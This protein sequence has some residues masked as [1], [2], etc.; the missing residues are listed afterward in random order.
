M[1]KL[2]IAALLIGVTSFAQEK[3]NQKQLT[4]EQRTEKRL[5]HLKKDLQLNSQQEK[6][7]K[8]ALLDQETRVAALKANKKERKEGQK[9]TVQEKLALKSKVNKEQ[10]TMSAK[11]KT[12]LTPEQ[13]KKWE[14]GKEE[15]VEK[16]KKQMKELQ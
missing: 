2:I 8:Q 9:L 5:E 6:Q 13:F 3:T 15:R 4:P 10:E 11:L 7:V 16:M 14:S 1:K 12:I